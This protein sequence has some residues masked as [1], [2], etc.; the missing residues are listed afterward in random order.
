M[1][2]K[3]GTIKRM[4]CKI[5]GR[6]VKMYWTGDFKSEYGANGH[7]GWLCLHRGR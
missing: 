1:K 7:K 2:I 3:R 5:T 6:K 4:K